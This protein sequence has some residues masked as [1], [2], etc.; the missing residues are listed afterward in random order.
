MILWTV[1]VETLTDNRDENDETY[2]N[3][4][5][6][7][8]LSACGIGTITD[9]GTPDTEPPGASDVTA[10]WWNTATCDAGVIPV[11]PGNAVS[12]GLPVYGPAL[13]ANEELRYLNVSVRVSG[14][15]TSL[16]DR[17]TLTHVGVPPNGN[18]G[19]FV[20]QAGEH[21]RNRNRLGCQVSGGDLHVVC[22]NKVG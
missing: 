16:P 15:A 7:G 13:T 17:L 12:I 21:H 11:I 22:A 5:A 20:E 8:G 10:G 6:A 18:R 3:A 14:K 2:V 4:T 1:S 19:D 9:A